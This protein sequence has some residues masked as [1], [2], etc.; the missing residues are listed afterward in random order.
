MLTA[1]ALSL[2]LA[3]ED[4]QD[5]EE[6]WTDERLME[7]Y[8]AT[9]ITHVTPREWV[10]HGTGVAKYIGLDNLRRWRLGWICRKLQPAPVQSA[11]AQLREAGATCVT[12]TH[13]V[14]IIPRADSFVDGPLVKLLLDGLTLP[15]AVAALKAAQ[16]KSNCDGCDM[17]NEAQMQEAYANNL[18]D[19]LRQANEMIVKLE[20][21]VDEGD[22]EIARLT[23][24][25]TRQTGQVVEA[26]TEAE[27]LRREIAEARS[28]IADPSSKIRHANTHDSHG[29]AV[30]DWLARNKV[31]P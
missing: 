18:K 24:C 25:C 17:P 21:D 8:R 3:G 22:T 16:G 27:R 6:A 29:C 15:D 11:E 5:G 7:A 1:R 31:R 26:K 9:Q 4:L 20:A 10:K 23:E 28:Y 19:E 12:T 13:D 2:P 30:C 14:G